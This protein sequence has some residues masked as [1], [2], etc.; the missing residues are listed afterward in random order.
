LDPSGQV[1]SAKAAQRVDFAAP[2]A[3][4]PQRL[5]ALHLVKAAISL[6]GMAG[7]LYLQG[8][9]VTAWQPAGGG[10]PVLFTSPNAVF[11]PARAIR[12]GIPIRRSSPPNSASPAFSTSQS[13][14]P[15]GRKLWMTGGGKLL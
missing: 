7:E 12:G 6:G 14:Q 9:Q 11:A 1:R 10:R 8:A 2:R 5:A 13:S 4:R 3:G 15:M